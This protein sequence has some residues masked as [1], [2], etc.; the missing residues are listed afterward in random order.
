MMQAYVLVQTNVNHGPI[1]STLRNIS[2]VA[3]ADDLTGPYDAIVVADYDPEGRHIE[4]MVEE[5][6]GIPGVIHALVAP[7]VRSFAG[8]SSGEAA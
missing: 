1:A 5:I 6:K 3:S 2:G 7:V 8:S 4:A